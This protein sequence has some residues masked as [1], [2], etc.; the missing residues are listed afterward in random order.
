VADLPGVNRLFVS[1][2]DANGVLCGE[3]S[4]AVRTQ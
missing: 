1:F 4:V 2:T 3:T